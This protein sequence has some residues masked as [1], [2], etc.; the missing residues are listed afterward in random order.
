MANDV[1]SG[2]FVPTTNVWDVA[3]IS[4]IDV[5]SPEFKELL[6]RLYQNLNLMSTVLNT[7]DTGYYNL[8]QYSCG[9]LFFPN[10]AANS[11]NTNAK[12]FR[13]VLRKVINFGTLPNAAVATVAHG[14]TTTAFTQFTRIYACATDPADMEYLPIPYASSTA[15]NNIELSVDNTNVTITTGSDRTAFTKCV[16]VLEYLQY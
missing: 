8:S 9:Q 14:I 16:V 11:T 4:D 1:V 15:A 6:I 10:P 2:S 5:T 13:Q 3:N 7:K 12:N